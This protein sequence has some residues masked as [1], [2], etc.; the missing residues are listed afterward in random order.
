MLKEKKNISFN[1]ISWNIY[2]ILMLIQLT[3][4][5]KNSSLLHS[6]KFEDTINI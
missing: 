1:Q 3:K 5:T 2:S 4:I 6:L